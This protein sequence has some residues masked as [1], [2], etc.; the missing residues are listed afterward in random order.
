[1]LI[2]PGYKE[3]NK[4]LHSDRP[5][6]GAGGHKWAELVWQLAHKHKAESVLDFGAGKSTL[7]QALKQNEPAYRFRAHYCCKEHGW[8]K[9]WQNFDPAI[10]GLDE[11]PRPA[12]LVVS[13]DC[14]E[15]VE[16]ECLVAVLDEIRRCTNKAVLLVVA[17]RPAK[18]TLPDGRNAHLVQ[19]HMQWWFGHLITRFDVRHLEDLGGEFVFIGTPRVELSS[20]KAA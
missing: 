1:M 11:A 14:L 6:Y 16:P 19:E 4:S 5:D 18:K 3:Q 2:T 13:T 15:H 17:T 7:H 9:N 12:D 20:E 10:E 8:L